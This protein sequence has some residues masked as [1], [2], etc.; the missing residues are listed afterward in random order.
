M[1]RNRSITSY[2]CPQP[3]PV[4][5]AAEDDS[6]ESD[7]DSLSAEDTDDGETGEPT[8][9]V[10]SSNATQ[11]TQQRQVDGAKHKTGYLSS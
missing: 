4:K 9:A 10:R 3:P 7:S 5:Y 8:M 11:V 1:K 6:S 2:F